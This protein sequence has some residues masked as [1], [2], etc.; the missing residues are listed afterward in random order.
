L[1]DD[2]LYETSLLS[3]GETFDHWF[4]RAYRW[5]DFVVFIF[6]P[7]H[8]DENSPTTFLQMVDA[9]PYFELVRVA[10]AFITLNQK[11]E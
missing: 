4:L 1:N 6:G 3:H 7:R 11:A 9:E 8:D 10:T 2:T 5:L